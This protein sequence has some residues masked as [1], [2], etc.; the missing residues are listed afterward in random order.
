MALSGAAGR[1]CYRECGR[2]HRGR[3]S[4]RR[5]AHGSVKRGGRD[6]ASEQNE[7]VAKSRHWA[8]P[9]VRGGGPPGC[10]PAKVLISRRRDNM[11]EARGIP[12]PTHRPPPTAPV[13]R[14]IEP[15]PPPNKSESQKNTNARRAVRADEPHLT[16]TLLHLPPRQTLYALLGVA[17][18][19]TDAQLKTAYRRAAKE[20]HP[21][22]N[23]G[24]EAELALFTTSVYF[25]VQNTVQVTTAS[26]ILPWSM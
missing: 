2:L 18:N 1:L 3:H 15:Q 16:P 8:H 7:K 20:H 6:N 12:S 14:G 23:P 10:G 11:S 22:V 25:A 13:S 5:V 21:D 26:S 17:K 4:S 19:A 24:A 9:H